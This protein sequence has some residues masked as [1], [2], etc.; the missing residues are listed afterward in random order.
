M[1]RS[2]IRFAACLA[3]GTLT[4]LALAWLPP[5]LRP[6]TSPTW[7]TD[8]W[9]INDTRAGHYS[10]SRTALRDDVRFLHIIFA[11]HA[12]DKPYYMAAPPPRWAFT[13]TQAMEG[14]G[15]AAGRPWWGVDTIATGWPRR[16]FRGGLYTPWPSSPPTQPIFT[17]VPDGKGGLTMSQATP[18]GPQPLAV[19]LVRVGA[20]SYTI[21][22]RPIASGLGVNVGVFTSLWAVAGWLIAKSRRALRNRRNQCSACGYARQGRDPARPCPECGHDSWRFPPLR[23]ARYPPPTAKP[24]LWTRLPRDQPPDLPIHSPDVHP[25]AHA[26]CPP[27][28]RHL[29]PP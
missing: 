10:V 3:L 13:L 12:K 14:D 24:N 1:A 4:T 25:S 5:L 19:G 15:P 18:T 28:A 11:G 9:W 27:T 21:P 26:L 8:Q 7:S 16:A 17:F 6:P 22:V 20:Q 23:S 2:I 29:S